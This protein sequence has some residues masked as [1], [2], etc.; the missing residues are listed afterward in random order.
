MN[1]VTVGRY[2]AHRL[3]AMGIDDCFTV[4]GDFNLALLGWGTAVA[5]Y[6]SGAA[7]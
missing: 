4:P 2:L 3:R 5:E 1:Q 7:G 6:N